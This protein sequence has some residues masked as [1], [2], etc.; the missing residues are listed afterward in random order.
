MGVSKAPA[1][2]HSALDERAGRHNLGPWCRRGWMG[3]PGSRRKRAVTATGQS[4]S[5]RL[6]ACSWRRGTSVVES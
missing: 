6:T 3:I 2:G 4:P 1:G 5:S